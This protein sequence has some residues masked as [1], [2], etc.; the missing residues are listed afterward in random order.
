MAKTVY[1]RRMTHNSFD[2]EEDIAR[3]I[4]NFLL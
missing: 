2:I 1:P 3:P 4:R